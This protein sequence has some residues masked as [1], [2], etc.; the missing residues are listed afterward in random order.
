MVHAVIC[1]GALAPNSVQSE[2]C[3]TAQDLTSFHAEMEQVFH[4]GKSRHNKFIDG[5]GQILALDQHLSL[6]CCENAEHEP[7]YEG[8]R[9]PIGINRDAFSDQLLG[10]ASFKTHGSVAH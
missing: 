2:S 9:L 10:T 5:P 6:A 7:E 1:P 4:S 3:C 8:L